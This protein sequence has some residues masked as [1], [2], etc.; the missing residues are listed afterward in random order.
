[1]QKRRWAF[2]LLLALI[3]VG[4]IEL[5]GFVAMMLAS[6]PL[7]Y[8]SYG[9]YFKVRKNLLGTATGEDL[10]R[11]TPV[12]TLNYI[13]TPGYVYGG[14]VQ[15]NAAGYR[16]PLVPLAKSD[17][18]RILFLG[19]STTW[20]SGVAN[21]TKTYPAQCGEWLNQYAQLGESYEVINAG[22]ESATSA[23]ELLAYH[24]KYRYYQPDV[25]VI[26][27]AGNDALTGP[28]LPG[29]QPDYTH[30]RTT[31]FYMEPAPAV[32]RVFLRSYFI[33]FLSI[34]LYY[35][36]LVYNDF[37]LT[38]HGSKNA[39]RWFETNAILDTDTLRNDA[40]YNNLDMLIRE[41]KADGA[42]VMLLP[43][44]INEKAEFSQQHPYYVD[45]LKAL[46]GIIAALARKHQTELIPFEKS[47]IVNESSWVDDCHL[48]A[49]G[50][51]DKAQLVGTYLVKYF[52][53][54]KAILPSPLPPTHP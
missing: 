30:Y 13:P 32:A 11:Y 7:P 14:L 41:I 23:E 42:R 52:K 38:S 2:R 25:V 5:C 10:P 51:A 24:F 21:P 29:Y 9:D 54:Q 22:V 53:Q 12:A 16:G 36:N 37:I 6:H 15:H 28:D 20:G 46:N 43:F 3:I 35:R 39:A 19:G 17:K 8:M 50:E 44:V 18:K 27:S 40:F 4:F 34:N 26:H 31:N 49:L 33:S 45:R 48:D 1:M 47:T